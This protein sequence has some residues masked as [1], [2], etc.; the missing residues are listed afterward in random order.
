LFYGGTGR[1]LA[2]NICFILTIVAWAGCI[3]FIFYHIIDA[4]V[5]FWDTFLTPKHT[6][7]TVDQRDIPEHPADE[8]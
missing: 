1:Q 6:P 5:D 3:S 8:P 7:A 4:V 2:A